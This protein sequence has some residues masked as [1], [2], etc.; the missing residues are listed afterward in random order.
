MVDNRPTLL[1]LL[2]KGVST[3]LCSKLG[4]K[5][6]PFA[7]GDFFLSFYIHICIHRIEEDSIPPSH[8]SSFKKC[9]KLPYEGTRGQYYRYIDDV[10]ESLRPR[11]RY[12]AYQEFIQIASQF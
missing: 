7:N 11:L 10:Q 3:L 2:V 1:W 8:T 6:Y 12:N 4:T 9:I 5:P